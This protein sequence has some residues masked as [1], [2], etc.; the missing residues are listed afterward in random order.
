MVLL[1]LPSADAPASQSRSA[2]LCVAFWGAAGEGFDLQSE[3]RTPWICNFCDAIVDTSRSRYD[4]VQVAVRMC[5]GEGRGF[6]HYVTDFAMLSA[7]ASASINFP[8]FYSWSVARKTKVLSE[9]LV[10][11]GILDVNSRRL[12]GADMGIR[13][14]N[15]EG[16]WKK[17]L[18]SLAG[19]MQAEA[20]DCHGLFGAVLLHQKGTCLQLKEMVEKQGGK[21]IERLLIVVAGPDGMPESVEKDLESCLQKLTDF[22]LLRCSVPGAQDSSALAAMFVFHDQKVLLPYLAYLAERP[23]TMEKP[24]RAELQ[25]RT[26]KEKPVRIELQKR[27]APRKASPRMV[28]SPEPT[29]RDKA[30]CPEDQ[31]AGRTRRLLPRGFVTKSRSRRRDDKPRLRDKPRLVARPRNALS[32]N[33]SSHASLRAWPS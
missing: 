30:R 5:A 12:C 27:A 4:T 1:A 33:R 31:E 20:H 14:D 17:A 29:S 16:C 26:R 25:K 11:G 15:T 8:S 10:L 6:K 22:P 23:L 18:C 19:R 32:W 2:S 13:V 3:S 21:Q 7:Q 24:A 28:A 9:R